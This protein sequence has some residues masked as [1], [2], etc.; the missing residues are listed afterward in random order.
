MSEVSALAFDRLRKHCRNRSPLEVAEVFE[1]LGEIARTVGRTDFYERL[2]EI[3][4]AMLDCDRWLVVRYSRYGVP[5]FIVNRAMSDEALDFY[6]QR[7][8][9]LDPLLRL[10]RTG[11]ETGVFCLSRLRASDR[12]NAYFDD[13]FRSA[14]IFDEITT[15]FATPGRVSIAVCLDRADR[16]FDASEIRV[17]ETV[18][19]LLEGLHEAHLDSTFRFMDEPA[20]WQHS[21]SSYRCFQ[22]LDKTQRRIYAT[23][24]W[25]EAEEKSARQ[26]TD[27]VHRG[28]DRGLV[29]LSPDTVLHWDRLPANFAPAPEGLICVIEH[30]RQPDMQLDFDDAVER[31]GAS[32]ELTPREQQIVALAFRGYPNELIAEKLGLSVGTVRNHRHRL[33]YKL[34]ITTEREL[35][36]TFI[37][38]LTAETE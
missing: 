28:R 26:L 20:L 18:F 38:Y 27:F 29:S 37:L 8:Y 19:P 11:P 1:A 23:A 9:R 15:L 24:N 21:A 22:I 5:E 17:I 10:A 14:W 30:R 3:P 25:L 35:F 16:S 36:H 4:A 7:L 13:L 6:F 31:F 32:H 2:A 12:D 34:D 33:Y